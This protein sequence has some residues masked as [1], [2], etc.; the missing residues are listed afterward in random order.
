MIELTSKEITMRLFHGTTTDNL[1]SIQSDGIT[2]PS[3]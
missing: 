3:Y 1:A 2:A